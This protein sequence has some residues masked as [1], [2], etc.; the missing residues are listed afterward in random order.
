M[1]I[2]FNKYKQEVVPKMKEL[3]SYGNIMAIPKIEKVVL[4]CGISS[5]KN[6]TKYVESVVSTLTKISGQKPVLTK[7]RDSISSFKVREGQVVGVKV[8][9]RRARMWHFLTKLLFL[10]LP[11]VRDFRGLSPKIIDSDGNAS[12]GFKENNIFPE[13]TADDMENI[14][15]LEICV[16]TTA[17]DKATGLSLLKLLGFPFS[18]DISSAGR[19]R[20]NSSGKKQQVKKK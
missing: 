12:I 15:G 11:N 16:V 7:A 18:E 9:L 10:T 1:D 4:N 2:L 14:H 20:K 3:F 19:V 8:T 5:A 6:E 17:H 13:M